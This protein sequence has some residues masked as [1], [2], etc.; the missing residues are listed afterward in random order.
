MITANGLS[1][2]L[3]KW[4]GSTRR[5]LPGMDTPT[6]RAPARGIARS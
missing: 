1:I 5:V 3:N 6:G 4:K 2:T